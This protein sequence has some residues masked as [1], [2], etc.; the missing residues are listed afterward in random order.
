MLCT[1]HYHYVLCALA[2]VLIAV[3]KIVGQYC[4]P[5]NVDMNIV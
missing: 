1:W 4:I 2:N 3:R 5:M